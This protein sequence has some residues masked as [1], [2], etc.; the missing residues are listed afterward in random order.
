MPNF[1]NGT[2]G[3]MGYGQ[4]KFV[5]QNVE[6]LISY[7]TDVAYFIELLEDISDPR[8]TVVPNARSSEYLIFDET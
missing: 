7:G 1:N 6:P 2:I 5:E 3:K 8:D 4:E